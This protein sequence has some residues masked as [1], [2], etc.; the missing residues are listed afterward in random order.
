MPPS[1]FLVPMPPPPLL[2]G[3]AHSRA[4]PLERTECMAAAQSLD[5]QLMHGLLVWPKC[6]VEH[7][8]PVRPGTA[9]LCTYRHVQ[10]GQRPRA[11]CYP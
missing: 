2:L 6:H 8:L 3:T 4:W 1:E 11:L 5:W 7:S 10:G 9:Q